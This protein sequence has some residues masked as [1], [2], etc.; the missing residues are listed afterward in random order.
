MGKTTKA[1]TPPAPAQSAIYYRLHTLLETI[2]VIKVY[3]DPLCTLLHAIR[4]AGSASGEVEHELGLLLEEMPAAAYAAELNDVRGLL[5]QSTI[6]AT[7]GAKPVPKG[8][9]SAPKPARKPGATRA[10]K[11][12]PARQRG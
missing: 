7:S 11:P 5:A 6:P 1:A 4:T 10:A 12:A 2:R 8:I 9:R 3:E